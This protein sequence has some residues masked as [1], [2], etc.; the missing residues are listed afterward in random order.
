M[1]FLIYLGKMVL[2]SGILYG[3]Y[4]LFLRNKRFHHYNRFYLL[5][6]LVLSMVL[7]LVSLPVISRPENKVSQAVYQ[8][9]QAISLPEQKAPAKQPAVAVAAQ[10][11][12][13]PFLTLETC[14]W[15]IYLSGAG[16][17][18]LLLGR[19][20]Y[21]VYRLR[22]RYPAQ[23]LQGFRFH[24]T[25]EAGTPFSFFG[26]VFWDSRIDITSHSGRQILRHELFHVQQ[27]H[28]A[29]IVLA[30]LVTIFGWFNP[31]FRLLKK[32][33]K[34]I[35]EFLADEH[36]AS[37]SDRLDYAR[38]LVLHSA[39]ANNLPL[40]HY[41]SYNLIKRR[42]TMITTFHQTK[43]GYGSRLMA[44]PLLLV[45]AGVVTLKAQQ[46]ITSPQKQTLAL[47][48]PKDVY[49]AAPA[50]PKDNSTAV[51][52]APAAI[53]H[54]NNGTEQITLEKVR[55]LMQTVFTMQQVAEKF[56]T[57]SE[58]LL[59]PHSG[60]WLYQ[61][62]NSHLRIDFN[63]G[64]DT[65]KVFSYS[66]LTNQT[67]AAALHYE[68]IRGIRE[69]ITTAEAVTKQFGTP[70]S[71]MLSPGRERWDYRNDKANLSVEFTMQQSGQVVN[72]FTYSERK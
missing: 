52:K 15:A 72:T 41:F 19:S 54:E 3:Y 57:P 16:Y 47:Y 51:V 42:I 31:F 4:H 59:S 64:T 20:L 62:A 49:A 38:L 8:A 39:Q 61:D 48:A 65:I 18:L 53:T 32:E 37:G 26:S 67:P 55:T 45:V 71:L 14:L 23:R 34:T 56:G 63:P 13:V 17:G 68:A 43:Y 21:Q 28:S 60:L 5:G 70:S 12:P 66:L 22:R 29:D 9:V 24:N 27:R 10:K 58:K 1:I 69:G 50:Q 30:E 36:A 40:P 44:L 7:P 33:L 46:V 6:I 11:D 2:C 35:H 25:R